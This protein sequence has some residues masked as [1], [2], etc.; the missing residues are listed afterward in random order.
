MQVAF[1]ARANSGCVS[2]QVGA[3]VTDKYDSVKAV[4]WNDVPAGQVP[5]NLRQ[6]TELLNSAD[7]GA[8]SIYEYRDKNFR[9]QVEG[10][11]KRFGLVDMGGRSSAFCFKSEYNELKGED[12]QVHTRS[13]HAE[14]NAFLQLAKYGS[15]GIHG[16][17]CLRPQVPVSYAQKKHTSLA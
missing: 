5:C 14:E 13:L 9:R 2:R 7:E 16:G 12:N 15:E 6:A 11:Y 3:A 1:S 8:F 10:S 4:G 17:N